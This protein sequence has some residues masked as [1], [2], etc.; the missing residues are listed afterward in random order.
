MLDIRTFPTA[1]AAIRRRPKMYIGESTLEGLS[2]IITQV[3]ISALLPESGNAATTVA[4]QVNSTGGLVIADNGVGLDCHTQSL[5]HEYPNRFYDYFMTLP[6][7]S[8]LVPYLLG[9]G[10]ILN[11]LCEEVTVTTTHD[12][13]TWTA[14]F[15][16]GGIAR[17]MKSTNAIVGTQLVIY[18]DSEIFTATIFTNNILDLIAER[19]AEST[20]NGSTV[21][22][23]P[24]IYEQVQKRLSCNPDAYH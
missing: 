6:T 14:S 5:E 8:G 21:T 11:A 9:T 24:S 10:C 7:G 22:V 18:P 16:R 15:S 20:P 1:G 13:G 12:S 3:C 4:L 17:M 2:H 19:S 23:A